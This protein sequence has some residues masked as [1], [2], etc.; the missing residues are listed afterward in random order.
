M[1]VRVGI[2]RSRG[3]EQ[4]TAATGHGAVGMRRKIATGAGSSCA[5]CLPRLYAQEDRN[6]G[7]IFLR[8]QRAGPSQALS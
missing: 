4:L 7:R 6:R 1:T 8:R 2:P 3:H 5:G